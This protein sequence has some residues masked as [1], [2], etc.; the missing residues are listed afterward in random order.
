MRIGVFAFDSDQIPTF[1]RPES[2]VV[3]YWPDRAVKFDLEGNAIE[4]LDH[5]Y[6]LGEVSFSIG[7]RQMSSKELEA[8]FGRS[9]RIVHIRQ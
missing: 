1:G 4:A 8:L 6:R 9:A 2:V 7:K 3:N 5:A